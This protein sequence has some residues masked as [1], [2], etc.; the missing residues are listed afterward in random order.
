MKAVL[1]LAI[2]LGVACA[3]PG[4]TPPQIG[5]VQDSGN[6]LRPVLGIAGN[7]VLGDPSQTGV[8]AAAFSGSSGMV[9]TD[10]AL[11]AIDRLGNVLASADAPS[12]AALFAF[13]PAGAPAFAYLTD[14]NAWMVWDGQAFQSVS[15]DMSAMGT[16]VAISSQRD[17]EGAVIVQRD[18]GLW[19]VRILLAT[20][21]VTSETA[22]NGVL[23]PLL[24]LS[25]GW[26]IY[27]DT[28]GIVVRK[29]DG[30]E[31]HIAAQLPANIVLQQMGDGWIQVR[32]LDTLNQFAVRVTENREQFY[33]L[34]GVDQ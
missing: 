13:S 9:K 24:A 19:D 3:Q 10:F 32:D 1:I 25:S 17:G 6:A 30:T 34:P 7:F 18:D 29:P 26:L 33:G 11:L 31:T 28:D 14:A 8:I 21:E 20:G 23:A 15:M 4:L 12:S 5:F 27:R 22:I 2:A 16:V